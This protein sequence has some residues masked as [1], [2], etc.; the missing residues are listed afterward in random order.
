[1]ERKLNCLKCEKEVIAKEWGDRIGRSKYCSKDC[2]DSHLIG[3]G[4]W[5]TA[6]LEE[7]MQRIKEYYDKYVIKNPGECWG[8]SG[9]LLGGRGRLYFGKEAVQA[10][11][12]SW[13]IHK[14]THIPFGKYVCHS[15]DNIVCTNPDHLFLGTPSENIIDMVM[16]GR[17]PYMKLKPYDIPVIRG[18]LA[19]GMSV[20]ELC[21]GY[22]VS[23]MT[24]SDIK[25]N[26]TWRHV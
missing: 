13:V 5:K 14:K 9:S 10:H 22:R 4:F 3:K 25:L 2:K 15:C 24:I 8:W 1:M 26:K 11:R 7:R 16:K 23:P 6:S 20:K 12:I 19:S 18:L 21:E 17:K